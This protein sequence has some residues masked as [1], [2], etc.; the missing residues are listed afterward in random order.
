M[1]ADFRQWHSSGTD[2]PG[3]QERDLSGPYWAQIGPDHPDGWSWT[4]IDFSQGDAD[5]DGG[6]AVD[7][8]AAK[9]AVD[10]WESGRA[11]EN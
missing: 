6:H 1:P 5:I 3:D 10:E 4:I 8:A 7:E 9:R 11:R 2:E